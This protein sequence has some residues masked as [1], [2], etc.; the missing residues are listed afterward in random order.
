MGE[1]ATPA[2]PA[3]AD[4][5]TNDVTLYRVVFT[6]IASAASSSSRIEIKRTPRIGLNDVVNDDDGDDRK[7]SDPQKIGI[8]RHLISR[9]SADGSRC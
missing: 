7:D 9:R 5:M 1:Q 8:A 2:T 4:P 6:P 3:K